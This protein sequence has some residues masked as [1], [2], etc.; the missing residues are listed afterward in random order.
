VTRQ[1]GLFR[2][3]WF[4][5]TEYREL[6]DTQLQRLQDKLNAPEIITC[7]KRVVYLHHHSFDPK[8]GLF[9]CLKD[10][11]ELKAVIY[12]KVDVLLY[13]HNHD[14]KISNGQWNIPRCYDAGSATHK[15]GNVPHVNQP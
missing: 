13:G 1:D 10:S 4:P 8:G 3:E 6:G 12:G 9:H 5:E 14:G 2:G 15:D 11:D 7:S